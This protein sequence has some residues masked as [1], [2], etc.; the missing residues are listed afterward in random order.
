MYLRLSILGTLP[1]DE[2]WSVN[3]AYHF[4]AIFSPAWDQASADAIVAALVAGITTTTLPTEL[5]ALMSSS[6][7][8]TGFRLEGR[9][10]S[11]ELLGVAEAFYVTPLTGTG[12]AS[13]PNQAAV[14][15]SLRTTTPGARGRGRM[16]W[17][18]LAIALSTTTGRVLTP[19]PAATA[20]AFATLLSAIGTIIK[21]NAGVFPWTD[22]LLAVRSTTD[23]ASRTVNRLQVGDVLDTQRRRRDTL[24]ENYSAVNY[25]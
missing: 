21:N 3:P 7:A 9:G 8:I 15:C 5:K 17:P 22:V 14:V 11:E 23:H 10:E 19:T 18:A 24:P 25:P 4:N 1:G 13:K 16:Y 12:T 2:K 6:A 20:T